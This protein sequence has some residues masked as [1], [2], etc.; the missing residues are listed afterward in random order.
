MLLNSQPTTS[1][2]I[3]ETNGSLVGPKVSHMCNIL[4]VWIKSLRQAWL[5]PCTPSESQ[6]GDK[7]NLLS[8]MDEAH[9][10][11]AHQ[12]EQV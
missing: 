9:R 7:E 5:L 4:S 8:G 6:G 10:G 1:K 12:D 3:K 2:G 11:P